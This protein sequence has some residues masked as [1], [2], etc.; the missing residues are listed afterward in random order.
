MSNLRKILILI[1]SFYFCFFY[2]TCKKSMDSDIQRLNGGQL[3][4]GVINSDLEIVRA[5]IS[6]LL[7]DLEPNPSSQDKFGHKDNF[8]FTFRSYKQEHRSCIR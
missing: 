6:K 7:S 4:I 2:S 5:E 1:I 3:K 8:K